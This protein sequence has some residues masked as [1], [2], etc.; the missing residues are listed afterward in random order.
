MAESTELPLCEI[1]T[2]HSVILGALF[3]ET[4]L[5]VVLLNN[6]VD[7][8]DLGPLAAVR[9]RHLMPEAAITVIPRDDIVGLRY[10]RVVQ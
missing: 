3:F 8:A 9:S 2:E 4:E 1:R 10:L 5:C 7:G 6:L